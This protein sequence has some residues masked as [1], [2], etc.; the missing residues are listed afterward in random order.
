MLNN[1]GG[2]PLDVTPTFYSSGGTKLQLAPINVREASYAEFDVREMLANAGAEFQEGSLQMTYLGKKMQLGS[3]VKLI[4]T[5]DSLI[6]EEQFVE[7]AAKYVSSQLEAVWWMPSNNC[8]TKFIISNTTG[9]PVTATITI[10]GTSPGQQTPAAIQLD[11]HETRVLDVIRDLV[12]KNNGTL[13][14]TG[15]VSILHTG[16]AGAILARMLISKANKGF[17]N[18]FY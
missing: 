18:E 8:D 11:A 17:Y 6:W 15:G 12:K 4:D 16:T 3:Q 1:K 5:A 14:T 9:A 7:P 10:D 13:H 2:L